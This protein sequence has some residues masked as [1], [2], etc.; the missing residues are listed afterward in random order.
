MFDELER[1]RD[2]TSLFT[3][4]THYADLGTSDRQAW[5]DR[6]MQF[7]DCDAKHLTR[8]HGELIAYGWLEQ[9]TGV[10]SE[11]RPNA[12]PGCYRVTRDGL[13]AIKQVRSGEMD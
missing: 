4:L 1:L 12:V 2:V 3:L 7:D 11:A 5:Q 6:R 9:N 13:R 8:L 10:V